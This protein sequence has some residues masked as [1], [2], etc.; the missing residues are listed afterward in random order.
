MRFKSRGGNGFLGRENLYAINTLINARG[1]DALSVCSSICGN[2]LH[3][4]VLSVNT[5][6]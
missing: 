1:G 4:A 2:P 3:L 5:Y 6:S